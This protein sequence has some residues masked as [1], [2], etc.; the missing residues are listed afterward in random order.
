VS[1]FTDVSSEMIYPLLPLFLTG[2]LGASAQFLGAIEGAAESTASLLKLAS[3]W[4]SDRVRRRKPLV[5]L[6]Y[7][8]AS[9]MRPLVALAQSA[10]QVLAVRV[11]DRVGKGIR[12]SP[13]DA[14]I[15]DSVPP[16]LRGRAFGFHRAADH[17][18]A[19]VGPL[20]AFAVLRWS[21]VPMRT[22]FWLAAIPGAVAVA[23]VVFAVREVRTDAPSAL[24]PR[25]SLG[26]HEV[27]RAEGRGLTARYWR[28]LAVILV[29]TLGNST[30]AFLLLRAADLGVP[31]ALAPL[32]W[33]ALHVVKSASSAPGG[34]LSDR[35]GRA[36][37][38]VV[39][40]LLYAAVYAGFA[41]AREPWHAW[42][43]FAVYGIHFGLTE[44]TER[45]LVADLVPAD[46][47][48][49]AYGWY[50]LTIGLGAFPASFL[51]G[52][53]WTGAGAPA[54]FLMGSGLSLLAAAGIVFA[55][56]PDKS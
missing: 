19:V 42:A 3:G 38:L 28:T 52:V 11:G 14:L 4:W 16:A 8:I 46:R 23:V 45:A 6:G 54:A 17:A 2:V 43:L 7:G 37:T 24:G 30:D 31:V 48:G 22:V 27:P 36:P 21:D 29:F 53:L 15:A 32:L 1:F 12:N 51:F 35:V 18:G 26:E 40:W 9:A 49:T 20:I 41:L 25:P 39:G 33:A 55:L 56:R 44:G 10:G 5:L 50:H 47:R 13:R 34:A